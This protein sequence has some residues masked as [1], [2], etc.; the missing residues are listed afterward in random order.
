M[1]VFDVLVTGS[2]GHLGTALMLKLPSLGFNPV[3]LD[4]LASPTT[5]YV[6]SIADRAVVSRI[7]RENPLLR[8]VLHAA[9]LHKPHVGSHT[10][11]QFVETNITGTL[12]QLEEAARSG[13]PVESFIF[14]R[15]RKSVV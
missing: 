12:V 7:W 15:D 8:H 11:E 5:K 9:A 13:R 2:S 1:P 6:G 3:G 10:M 4:I 14:F